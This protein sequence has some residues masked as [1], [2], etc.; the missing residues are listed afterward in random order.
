MNLRNTARLAAGAL[1]ILG[2]CRGSRDTSFVPPASW[3]GRQV[4]GDGVLLRVLNEPGGDLVATLPE[5]AA[6]QVTGQSA[7][8]NGRLWLSVANDTLKGWAAQDLARLA[9][10]EGGHIATH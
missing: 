3:V 8:E 10:G 2:G 7:D 9:E 1:L 5:G 6:I 4:S